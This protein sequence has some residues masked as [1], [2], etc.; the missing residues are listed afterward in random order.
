M[1]R[2]REELLH[3]VWGLNNR[4]YGDSIYCDRKI[5]E[6]ADLW[7]QKDFGLEGVKRKLGISDIN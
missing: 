4:K 6:G 3:K 5:G 7:E 2:K 1:A